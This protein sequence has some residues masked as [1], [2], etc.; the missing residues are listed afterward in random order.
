M[1]TS[2]SRGCLRLHQIV[3]DFANNTSLPVGRLSSYEPTFQHLVHL[4][5]LPPIQEMIP[6]TFLFPPSPRNP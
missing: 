4:S 6:E 1:M 5:S 3:S 2:G